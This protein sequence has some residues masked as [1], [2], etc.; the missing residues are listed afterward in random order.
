ML[1]GRYD[2]CRL[3]PLSHVEADIGPLCALRCM[4]LLDA[5]SRTW[6]N[7]SKLNPRDWQPTKVHVYLVPHISV[8]IYSA[9]VVAPHTIASSLVS[10]KQDVCSAFN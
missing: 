1:I 3:Y 7:W 2:V 6:I 5:V 10:R 8:G 4:R 9:F